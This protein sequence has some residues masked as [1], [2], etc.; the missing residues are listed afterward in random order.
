MA[1]L[2]AAAVWLNGFQENRW[3]TRSANTVHTWDYAVLYFVRCAWAG[4]Y[5][6]DVFTVRINFSHFIEQLA[7]RKSPVGRRDI[8]WF[9]SAPLCRWLHNTWIYISITTPLIHNPLNHSIVWF[10]IKIVYIL[11]ISYLW[12]LYDSYN[13]HRWIY[14]LYP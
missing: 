4:N 10:N 13:K 2:S 14:F 7:F 12:V 8:S 5:V 3:R 9:R 11:H 1:L 6:S